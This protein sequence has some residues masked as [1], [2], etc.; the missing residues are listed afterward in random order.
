MN[1]G[2]A[3]KFYLK[4]K[5]YVDV[6][7]I[8]D[9]LELAVA[10]YNVDLKKGGKWLPESFVKAAVKRVKAYV[11]RYP[12]SAEHWRDIGFAV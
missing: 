1:H 10:K 11:K 9:L 2:E 3:E 6:Q 7:D 8:G 5:Q 4:V 12:D